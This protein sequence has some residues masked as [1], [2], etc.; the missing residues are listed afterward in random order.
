MPC[1]MQKHH[2]RKKQGEI[3]VFISQI[4]P[5]IDSGGLR[6]SMVHT[7]VCFHMSLNKTV[8]DK[9]GKYGKR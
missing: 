1:T 9:Y 4:I 7:I 3:I 5:I 2:S 6:R 8:K